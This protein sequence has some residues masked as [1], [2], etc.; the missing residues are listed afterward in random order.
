[1]KRMPNRPS[2][3]RPV[4]V[5]PGR[6][7][8][9]VMTIFNCRA[10]LFKTCKASGYASDELDEAEEEDESPK[11]KRKTTSAAAQAKA[12]EAA[13]KKAKK[14]KKGGDDNYSDSGSDSYNALSKALWTNNKT[15]P[16]VGS[17]EDCAKCAKQFTV[18]S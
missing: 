4:L 11:K 5:N 8:R 6:V 16:P 9:Y 3:W 15:K 13:K 2:R 7:A 17:F 1:M 12:K 18:V 10:F 14:G